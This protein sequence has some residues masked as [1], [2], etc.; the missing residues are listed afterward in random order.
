MTG[1]KYSTAF[2]FRRALEDRLKVKS[3]EQGTDFQRV[4]RS[5]AFDRLLCRLFVPG[6]EPWLLK[7]G[8]AMELRIQTARVTKDI[9]L[10]LPAGIL[11]DD[12][13]Q[14]ELLHGMLQ[15]AADNDLGDYFTFLIGTP[16]LDLD[17]APYGGARFPVTSLVAEKLYVKFHLDLG[18]GDASAK[19][20]EKFT[21]ADWLGF[22]GIPP[23]EFCGISREE[24]FAEKLHAYTRPREQRSNSRVKDLIDMVLLIDLGLESTRLRR[25]LEITFTR[26]NSH[27]LPSS[28]EAPPEFWPKPYEALAREC[29]LSGDITNG[30]KRVSDFYGLLIPF[31]QSD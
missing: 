13:N 31:E 4:R 5:V 6:G 12:G 14:N 7:G 25:A 28:L 29:G 1:K 21:G 16:M 15:D 18:V 2:A 27:P 10:T 24:Q 22:A 17:A 11:R 26:R 23:G 19:P 3:Q 30:F 20:F 8:Y 9:D